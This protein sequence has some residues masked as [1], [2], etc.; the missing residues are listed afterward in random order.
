MLFM[1]RDHQLYL[2]DILEACERI[3]RYTQGFTF[4]QFAANSLVY[5][6]VLRNIEIIGEAAKHIPEHVQQQ[7]SQ[8]E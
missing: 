5:D 4:E 7:Y 8:I 1:S 3:A 6:A 2:E